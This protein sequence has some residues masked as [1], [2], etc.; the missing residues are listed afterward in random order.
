MSIKSKLLGWIFLGFDPAITTLSNWKLT[1]QHDMLQVRLGSQVPILFFVVEESRFVDQGNS[2]F[3][4]G[5]DSEFHGALLDRVIKKREFYFIFD[6]KLYHAQGELKGFAIHETVQAPL[7][8]FEQE[9][10]VALSG[11][12][13]KLLKFILK[14]QIN[15]TIELS[16]GE[17]AGTPYTRDQKDQEL[18][19]IRDSVLA[20]YDRKLAYEKSVEAKAAAD[21]V[22]RS[23]L[24]DN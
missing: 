15:D 17:A 4:N 2:G 18:A 12:R 9:P 10:T 16:K 24:G 5:I 14:L 8:H 3:Y 20:Y 1:E 7:L 6:S 19:E 11:L 23:E 22:Q 13:F 21:R